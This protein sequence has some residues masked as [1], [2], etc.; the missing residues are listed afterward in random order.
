MTT[1]VRYHHMPTLSLQSVSKHHGPVPVL[2]DCTFVVD[3]PT[4][5][6]VEGHSGSGKTTLLRLVAGLE[7]PDKGSVRTTGPV[8]IVFQHPVL[9]PHLKVRE[10][11]AM[12]YRLHYNVWRKTWWEK[13]E[14]SALRQRL[15]EAIQLLEL[16]PYQGRLPSELSGGQRQRA[17]LGRCLVRRPAVFLLDEPL[18][19]LDPALASRL[20]T[21]L[22]ETFQSWGSTV[23]WV[24]HDPAEA[25]AVADRILTITNG[26]ITGDIPNTPQVQNE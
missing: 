17:A 12:G 5:V 1:S 7:T 14:P 11:L 26:R 3:N 4:I 24:T 23:L 2:L 8:G 18:A 21:S 10:N 6:A 19:S 16:D 25:R 22:R 15:D 9:M 20:R 13:T